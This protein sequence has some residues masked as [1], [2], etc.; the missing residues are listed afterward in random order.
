[1]RRR[2]N[3]KEEVI[4]VGGVEAVV[5]VLRPWWEPSWRH[6]I[7]RWRTRHVRALIRRPMP[8]PEYV[9]PAIANEVS[10]RFEEL[11]IY[12][13]DGPPPRG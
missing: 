6:P 4:E 10:D 5:T 12:G 9:D 1:M 13:P 8:V 7:R 3:E 11:V 2:L